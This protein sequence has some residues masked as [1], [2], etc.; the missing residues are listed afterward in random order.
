MSPQL[1]ITYYL[2]KLRHDIFG[3]VDHATGKSRVYIFDER[4]GPKNLHHYVSDI[5]SWVQRIH[6]FLDN[7]GGTNKNMY[8][9]AWAMVMAH[10]KKIRYCENKLHDSWP[11]K[12]L[13]GRFF[14]SNCTVLQ[15]VMYLVQ[16]S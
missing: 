13:S 11:Y 15:Q 16:L 12:I 7:A 2:Q 9:M 4:L 14:S 6:I 5:P 10:H 1:G 3:I 8:T